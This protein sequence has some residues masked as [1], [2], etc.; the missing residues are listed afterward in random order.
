DYRAPELT[1]PAR[2]SESAAHAG[3]GTSLA[4]WWRVFRDAPLDRL[5]A[6]AIDANLD[7][8][9]AESRVRE[10]RA[11]R[12]VVRSA[13]WP[14]VDGGAANSRTRQSENGSLGGA[15]RRGLVP[16]ETDL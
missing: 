7:L 2:Y 13:L 10:A 5:V 6:R 14:T 16:L 12:G 8:R 1:V 3:A 15:V 4:E 9:I 11:L